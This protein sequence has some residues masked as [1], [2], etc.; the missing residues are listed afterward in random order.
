MKLSQAMAERHS[1][2][3]F[4]DIPVDAV[5]ISSLVAMAQRSPSWG[6]TQPWRIWVAGG[7]VALS[8]R[9]GFVD[10]ARSG[11]PPHPDI[12]M[13][14]VFE[15][16]LKAR[17]VEI[18]KSVFAVLGIDRHDEE[19]RN[20]H[21]DN[22]CNAFGAPVLVYLTLPEGQSS[23]AMLDAGA[24]INAFCLAAADLGV[25]TCIQ[26]TLAHYPDIVRLH[27]PIPSEERI[28]V[29]VALGY[30]DPASDIN[31]FRSTREPVETMLTFTG[32]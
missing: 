13:P 29:G 25:A 11:R 9:Q 28:V 16:E 10:L 6:N 24:F 20:A 26:A 21:R 2:R 5:I 31:R 8:I 14:L 4:L 15:G 3:S 27:L 30:A 22:N 18:G 12:P 17:Y 32:F 1:C 19:K 7:S 23:Y